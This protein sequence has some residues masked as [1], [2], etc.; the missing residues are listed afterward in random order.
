MRT[1]TI[2]AN[3]VDDL[4]LMLE[5]IK[6]QLEEGYTAGHDN[7]TQHWDL[8]GEDEDKGRELEVGD[9]V[10][11]I[12]NSLMRREYSNQGYYAWEVLSVDN[13]QEFPTTRV[14]GMRDGVE[15]FHEI[16]RVFESSELNL[17]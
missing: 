2:N 7:S 14:L 4:T 10:Q 11:L 8:S 9:T 15:G 17:L 1:L 12:E 3:N 13:E 5:T 16:I 6:F